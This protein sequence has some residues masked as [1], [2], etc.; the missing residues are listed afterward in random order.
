MRAIDSRTKPS[1]LTSCG[2][3]AR[4]IIA[5]GGKILRLVLTIM[6]AA[7]AG[8]TAS[9]TETT[10]AIHG[11]VKDSSG[12]IVPYASVSVTHKGTRATRSTRTDGQGNFALP[13]LEPGRYEL[14]VEAAGFKKYIDSDVTLSVGQKLRIDP[15]LQVGEIT[16]TVTVSGEATEVDTATPELG[17]REDAQRISTLP[18]A[19]RNVLKMAIIQPGVSSPIEMISAETPKNLPGGIGV[20]PNVNGMRNNANNYL[21]DGSDNNEPFLGVAAVV[22][23]VESVQEFKVISG[24]YSAEYGRSGGSVV[25]IITKSGSNELHGSA[26]EF[27]RNDVLNARN[28]FAKTVRPLRRN[29]FGGTVGGPLLKSKT[30]F[31]ASYEGI[32]ERKGDTRRTTVPSAAERRGDFSFLNPAPVSCRDRGAVCD[33]LTGRPFPGNVIP[34]N[35]FDPASRL[36][37]DLWPVAPGEGSEFVSQPILPSNTDQFSIKIDQLW[38]NADSLSVRYFFSEGD[39]LVAFQPS[40]LGPIEVPGFEVRDFFRLQN[41]AVGEIHTFSSSVLNE[42]RFSYNRAHLIA[43]ENSLTN[44]RPSDFGFKF[45]PNEPRFFPAIAVTGYST[46]G[47]SD[48][49]NV[50]RFNNIYDFQDNM[51]IVRNRHE[52][53]VGFQYLRSR[54]NNDI[55]FDQPFFLFLPIFSGNS[56]ADFLLGNST[57]LI[58]GG[59]IVRRDYTSNKYNLYFQDNIR[60]R[61]N[62]TLNVGLRYE[63][64]QPWLEENGL[65]SAFVPGAQSTVR[66]NFPPGILY[67]GDAGVPKRGSITDKNN[68]APRIGFAWDPFKDGKTSI[69]AGYGVFYDAGDFNSER[70]Q[71]MV[72]P[73][74][75]TFLLFFGAKFS[76]PYP[77]FGFT[78]RGPWAPENINSTLSNPPPG[79]Q[80]NATDLKLRTAYAQHFSLSIQREVAAGYVLEAAYLGNTVRKLIGTIDLNQ[81]FLTP[82]ATPF[83][84]NLRRPFKPWGTINYQF[85]GLNSNYNGL[86]VTVEKRLSQG[87][88]FRGA[89]TWSKTIDYGSIP[90][91]FQKAVGQPVFPQDARNIDAERGPAA[92]DIRHRFVLSYYWEL[93]FFKNL[94]GAAK[95]FLDGWAISGITIFQAGT[96]ITVIDSSGPSLTGELSDRPDMVCDPNLPAGRR[97]VSRWFDTSCFKQVP[98]FGG[99]NGDG[100]GTAGRNVVRS[101]GLNVFDFSLIRNIALGETTKLQFRAEFFNLFNHPNFAPPAGDIAAAG[102]FGKVFNTRRDDERQIQFALKLTF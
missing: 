68:L 51:A 39:S 85:G 92:F 17:K 28:F 71:N 89:Y 11:T 48:F 60:V 38:G 54:L 23:S 78:S 33:P 12:A 35:R 55:P 13:L 27:L 100:R 7:F 30:F 82:T 76:D 66:P 99:I 73:G 95:K 21:L 41:L 43:G 80:I 69:R 91:T 34:E 18:L 50:N 57:L 70:F 19:D 56:F 93:P 20:S 72:G 67:V 94:S 102:T 42:F 45:E 47:T 25:N 58:S 8:T 2:L 74:F 4:A 6:V 75:Y 22:P 53:K 29:E 40:F 52:I 83:D 36:V 15:T 62:F 101:D 87:L 64:R 96:P 32:R 46:L 63:L 3:P 24:L 90:Q 59:G 84:I 14:S 88:S 79:T 5:I 44:R 65:N 49:N 98:P 16:D 61:P 77:A 31:F 1:I 37:R 9:A 26:W 81:P 10:G 86:Q 97:T